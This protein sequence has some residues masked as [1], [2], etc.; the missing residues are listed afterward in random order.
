M[1]QSLLTVA[2]LRTGYGD[3][4]VVW[5]VGLHVNP[6]SVTALLGR[7][8]TGKT[9]TLRAIAGINPLLAGTLN[10]DGADLRGVPPHRRAAMGLSFV[11]EGK[12]IFR[13][14]TVR[15]NIALGAY[16][17]RLKSHAL[18]AQVEEAC[19][20]FPAL[21]DRLDRP[22]GLLSGGQQQMLAIA[23]SLASKPRVLLLDE[24]SAGLSPALVA[25]VL[26]TITELRNEGMAIVLVEQSVD[27]ALEVAD[28]AVVIDLGR[29]TYTGQRSDPE[30]R[31]AVEGA[32]FAATNT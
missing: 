27:F 12:Q 2:N 21:A 10:F 32:Y 13:Q 14:R 3:L 4:T 30:F 15:E 19:A 17:R 29:V 26:Q 1:T 5:D 9:S 22:A 23:Q 28:R 20:R 7:N 11:Q 18:Q 25:E 31:P 8:G 6:G 24:P 16:S